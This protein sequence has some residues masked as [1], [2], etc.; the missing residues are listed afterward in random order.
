MIDVI[1]ITTKT[2]VFTSVSEI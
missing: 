1:L 2:I